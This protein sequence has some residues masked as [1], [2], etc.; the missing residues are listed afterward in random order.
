MINVSLC[1]T[2][3][4]FT[5]PPLLPVFVVCSSHSGVGGVAGGER[6]CT[7]ECRTTSS[8]SESPRLFFRPTD[9]QSVTVLSH[10]GTSCVKL[11]VTIGIVFGSEKQRGAALP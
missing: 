1:G 11:D 7:E 10:T 2:V 4:S 6:S 5:I 9:A 3:E 8:S